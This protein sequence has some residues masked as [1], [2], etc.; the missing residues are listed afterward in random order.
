MH[1][2]GLMWIYITLIIIVGFLMLMCLVNAG[3][4]YKVFQE[5][6]G[7][8]SKSEARTLAILN[9]ILGII[10]L[11]CLIGLIAMAVIDYR[12]VVPDVNSQTLAKSIW[13]KTNKNLSSKNGKT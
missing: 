4:L 9:L 7:E 10:L 12:K 11:L 1:V 2:L 5:G 3:Y 8:V 13:I 6:S